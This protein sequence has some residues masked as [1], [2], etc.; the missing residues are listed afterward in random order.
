MKVY[1]GFSGKFCNKQCYSTYT[2]KQSKPRKKRP[3]Q[4]S[5]NAPVDIM[6]DKDGCAWILSNY[7]LYTTFPGGQSKFFAS[8]NKAKTQLY[9]HMFCKHL[10]LKQVSRLLEVAIIDQKS[11]QGPE[12]VVVGYCN[13]VPSKCLKYPWQ[14]PDT[15]IRVW[16]LCLT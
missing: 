7:S 9:V 12:V 13:M 6:I 16:Y 8:K 14:R 2:Y 4:I 15:E 5:Y 10:F 1:Y 11:S 3:L